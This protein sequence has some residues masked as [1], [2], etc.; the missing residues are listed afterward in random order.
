MMTMQ[1]LTLQVPEV[2]FTRLKQ[3]AEQANR[4]VEA[5]MLDLLATAVPGAEELPADLQQAVTSLGSL[6][7]DAL[8]RAAHSRL[9]VEMAA[10][11]EALHLKRQRERLIEAETL[12]LA[13][14]VR[15]YERT[16]L[17]RA[18]AAALLRQRGHDVSSLVTRA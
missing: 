11:L 15:Q 2:L 8:W 18:Q 4:T 12:R 16:M 9:A 6:E 7:D 13:D 14:L 10:E 17:I 5:E 3:R 1:T